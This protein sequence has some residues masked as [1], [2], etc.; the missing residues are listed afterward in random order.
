MEFFYEKNYCVYINNGFDFKLYTG[1]CN[2][3]R[4]K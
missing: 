2:G 4:T 1:E 3:Q